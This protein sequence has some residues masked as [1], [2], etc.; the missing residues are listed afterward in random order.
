MSKTR[1]R[2]VYERKFYNQTRRFFRWKRIMVVQK[3][4]Q[5]VRPYKKVNG[6]EHLSTWKMVYYS[7]AK[8]EYENYLNGVQEELAIYPQ[9]LLNQ[10]IS[11]C[12]Q[13]EYNEIAIK[14]YPYYRFLYHQAKTKKNYWTEEGSILRRMYGKYRI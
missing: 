14:F 13:K 7:I 9:D 11:K 12:Y 5:H 3:F 4:I 8:K 10:L 6:K 2:K 1:K